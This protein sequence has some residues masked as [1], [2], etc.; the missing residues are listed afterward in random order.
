MFIYHAFRSLEYLCSETLYLPDFMIYRI[1]E[2]RYM[3]RL[4]DLD[5][6]PARRVSIIHEISM[7]REPPAFN[8]LNNFQ[9]FI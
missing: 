6:Q 5:S 2:E 7:F 8:K 1:T 3:H 4:C 9:K